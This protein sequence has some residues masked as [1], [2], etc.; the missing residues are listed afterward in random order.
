MDQG[1]LQGRRSRSILARLN[2]SGNIRMMSNA[3]A[4][5]STQAITSLLGFIYWWLAA[6]RFPEASVG[7]ASALVSAMT[8]LGTVGMLGLGTL[9]IGEL[10][11]NRSRAPTLITTAVLIAG[12]V[13]ALLGGLFT[14]IAPLISPELPPLADRFDHAALF[15]LGASLTAMGL[16]LDQAALGVMRGW[17][18]FWR[19]AILSVGKLAALFAI[20][21]WAAGQA[22]FSI[23]ATWVAGAGLSI[24]AVVMMEIGQRRFNA[25]Y[26]PELQAFQGLRL[27]ALRHHALNL[28]LLAPGLLL[29]LVVT[30][31]LSATVNAYFYT[32]WMLNG[33]VTVVPVALATVLFAAGAAQPQVLTQKFRFSIGVT[34]AFGLLAV[35]V[36]ALG[37]RWMLGLFGESYAREAGLAL[38]VLSLSVFP[39]IIS[40]HFVALRRI[41]RRPQSATVPLALASVLKLVL[42]AAGAEIGGLLGLSIG[43]VAASYLTAVFL[44]P[45]VIRVLRATPVVPAPLRTGE[46]N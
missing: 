35:F 39:I 19:N 45:P 24:L 4:L 21:T 32:A 15:I 46:Q 2:L 42:A 6:R 17:L 40:E 23:F 11:H 34:T 30:A 14:V 27:H 22:G 28:V 36:V 41:E 9:L 12:A 20:T 8:L 25:N 29:P 1:F 44:L 26:R 16:V 33:F 37:S 43:V 5:I 3:A 7:V 31:R 18:Q 38:V 13:G 10:P